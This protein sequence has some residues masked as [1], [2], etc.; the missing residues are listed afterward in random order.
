MDLHPTEEQHA[1]IQMA[2]GA[3]G[4]LFPIADLRTDRTTAERVWPQI[5]ELGLIGV[6]APEDM[7][8]VG[9]NAIDAVLICEAAGHHNIPVHFALAIIAADLAATSQHADLCADIVAGKTRVGLCVSLTERQ[10]IVAQTAPDVVL[11]VSASEAQ[12]FGQLKVGER[13]ACLDP[14]TDMVALSENGKSVTVSK[15]PH[16]RRLFELLISALQVGN[17]AA[18]LAMAVEH[19]KTREQFGK[20]IGSFQAVRH[21]CAEMARRVEAV[22]SLSW[23]AAVKTASNAPDADQL[24]SATTLLATDAALTNA[25]DTL[26]ILGAMGMTAEHDLQLYLKRAHLLDAVKSSQADNALHLATHGSEV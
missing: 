3:F 23:M 8:G 26:Q 21:V 25:A 17:A 24:V 18:T 16:S 12:L 11:Q 10:A 19:A 5:A 6:M 1:L 7:G 22:R 14:L 2:N 13:L 20:P 4:E 15:E 9:L